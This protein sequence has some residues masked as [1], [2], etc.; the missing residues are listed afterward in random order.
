[1][2]TTPVRPVRNFGPVSPYRTRQGR[3][4]VRV[5]PFRGTRTGPDLCPGTR[6]PEM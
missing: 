5:F 3:Y 6:R 4:T 2:T 1:M